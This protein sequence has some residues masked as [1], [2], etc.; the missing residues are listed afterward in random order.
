MNDNAKR[1]VEA[2]RSGKYTQAQHGLHP[3]SGGYCCLGVACDL[4]GKAHG[5]VF[6]LNASDDDDPYYYFLEDSAL[7]PRPVQEWLGLRTSDGEFSAPENIWGETT[8]AERNDAG[9]T[10]EEIAAIVESEPAGLFRG[11]EPS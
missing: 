5:I 2:L 8:L 1:W 4:Y 9:A 7:L 3:E 6:V 11:E 10:F